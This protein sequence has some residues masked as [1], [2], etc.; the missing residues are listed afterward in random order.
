VANGNTPCPTG[1]GKHFQA[2][3]DDTIT[4]VNSAVG[5]RSVRTWMYVVETEMGP[6]GECLLTPGGDGQPALQARWQA[7]LD[8]M[9]AGDTLLIQFGINDSSATCDRHVGLEAF[10]ESYGV[11]AQAAKAREAQ[12]V[13]ITPVSSIACDSNGLPKGTRGGY[14]TATLEAGQAF[15]VPVI[16]LHQRSVERYGE[17]GFCPVP[18]GDVSASTGGDVGEYFCDDHTHFSE[19]GA[20][21]IAELVAEGLRA[22]N[23]PIAQ[24]LK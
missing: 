5:G 16:D 20:P 6:D 10:K 13:F 18:G 23:L 8:G 15:D 3:F 14:V 24:A 19:T 4:V 7:M 9:Q 21:D 1:W 2:L 11:L 17:L 22:L 12:P